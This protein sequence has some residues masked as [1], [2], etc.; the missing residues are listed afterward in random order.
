MI[1]GAGET[2]HAGVI[3]PDI[4]AAMQQYTSALG[5]TWCTLIDRDLPVIIA[6][7]PETVRSRF[8]YSREGTTHLELVEENK[9]TIW[10]VGDGLHHAG[11]WTEDLPNDMARLEAAGLPCAMS[12]RSTRS[13]RP[14]AFSYHSLPSGGYLELV[15]IRMQ[16]A[17][18]RWMAGGD[19]A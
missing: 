15:E 18:D 12:G 6:G 9:E 1:G 2:Y 7:G 16:P 13:G 3:V 10:R 14:S 5:L 19:F 8:T 11:R 4:E 17:F